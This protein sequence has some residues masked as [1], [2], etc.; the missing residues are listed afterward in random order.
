MTCVV[1]HPNGYYS[2]PT[3]ELPKDLR[4]S[5]KDSIGVVYDD[6]GEVLEVRSWSGRKWNLLTGAEREWALDWLRS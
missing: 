2:N 1:R 5:S 4:E 3:E 6:D